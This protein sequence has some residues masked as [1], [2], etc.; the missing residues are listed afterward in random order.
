MMRILSAEFKRAI[1][2]WCILGILGT[3]F[4]ICFDSWND[5]CMGL[6]S[7]EGYDVYY[8][9]ENSAFGGMCRVYFLPVFAA[10]PFASS[11]SIERR[12][13]SVSYII[14]REGKKQYGIVKYIVNVLSGGMVVA[15]GTAILLFVL[16]MKFPMADQEIGDVQVADMFHGWIAVYHPWIY[17]AV[18]VIL[19]FCRGMI[20]S[21]IAL[22]VSIYVEDPFVVIVSPYMVN[23]AFIQFCRLIQVDNQHRFD[24]IL[25]GRTVIRSSLCTTAI[26]LIGTGIIVLTVGVIF[27]KKIIRGMEDGSIC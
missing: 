18:E 10:L 16:S 26:A 3:I 22:L 24:M 9:F 6:Q 4:S 14:T 17:C 27:A 19:G 23:Y 21:G 8:F 25:I 20:W 7:G 11:F 12:D 2:V 13:R 5:L 15:A 1:N